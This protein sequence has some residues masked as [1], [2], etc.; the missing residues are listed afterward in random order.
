[1]PLTAN[2]L[3]DFSSFINA[4]K[5]ATA[6][7]DE[8]VAAA[9]KVGATMD[10][11]VAHAATTLRTVG[12][13]V[14]D[15]G[16]QAWSVLNSS[17]LKQFGSDV[18]TFASGFIHEFSEAE[19]STSRLTAALK[20]AG[21]ASPEVTKAY[22]DM[23]TNLQKIS[24]FSDEA[25]TDAQTL[26]TTVGKIGPESMEATLRA[27]MDLAAGMAGQGMTLESAALL[28]AKAAA[29]DGESLGKLKL[30]L[31]DSIQPGASFAEVMEAIRRKFDGQFAAAVKTTA[32]S[33]ENLKN[34]MSDV[35]EQIGQ[36]FAENLK[37]LIGLFQSLPESVQT[38]IIAAVAIGTAIAPIL[39][40]L[41]SLVTLLGSTGIG[42][43]IGAAAGAI[44]EFLLPILSTLGGALLTAA[45]AVGAFV[46]GL[47][48][49][50]AVIIAAIVALAAGIYFYWDEIV[51]FLQKAVEKV[52]YFL[53]EVLPRAFTSVVETVKTWYY[54][55]KY[56]LYDQFVG[57]VDL[58]VKEPDR[59][60]D[61]FKWMFNNVVG[62]S[63]VPDMVEGIAKEFGR[64]DRV[65]V[66]PA[67]AAVDDVNAAFGEGVD[68]F[69]LSPAALA[70]AGGGAGRGASS[71]VTVTVNMSGMF[72]TDDPQTRS[73]V[74]DLV[75]NAVMQGMRGGRLL[76][77][78]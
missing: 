36:V 33:M 14:A 72:S 74:S 4:A 45:E 20:A 75:S 38:F 28:V 62:F 23:A 46:A 25:L 41:S 48:G 12:Q 50:P 71:P 22:A 52:K 24:T 32:G 34:Q 76:G 19:A 57:L 10:Q 39:I 16:K 58:L 9:G 2:F 35:N 18:A 49:W 60:S 68:P 55:M 66:D 30:I 77:T 51:A 17:Q 13:S 37:T 3:A 56:W 11:A 8:L 5:S 69:N 15:F 61:A 44:G 43:A 78:A 6:S 47:V 67:L 59:I 65:M 73:M 40:S 1:M 21:N 31:G 29:S 42:G 54:Q 53:T 27:T 26:F 70:G 63:Y 64:L 7:T